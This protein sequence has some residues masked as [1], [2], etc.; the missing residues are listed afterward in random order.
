MCLRYVLCV[1]GLL[2]ALLTAVPV[3]GA[4]KHTDL[5]P[6]YTTTN[7]AALLIDE[8]VK[9][10]LKITKDQTAAIKKIL[11]KSQEKSKEDA[12]KIFKMPKGPDSY[13]KIRA[14]A[15]MRADQLFQD[16]STTLSA[17]QVQRLKQIMLQSQGIHVIEHPE[18]RDQLKLSEADVTRLIALHD[19][20]QKQIQ[21]QGVGGK[22]TVKEANVQLFAMSKGIA[23]GIRAEL[24]GQQRQNLNELLGEPYAFRK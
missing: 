8:P 16:L 24:N 10:E 11:A 12:D 4:S 7:I 23:A 5:V 3:R 1:A 14:L 13:P 2:V 19:K 22:I 18:I 6:P 17:T 9:K 20:L 15:A 21:E